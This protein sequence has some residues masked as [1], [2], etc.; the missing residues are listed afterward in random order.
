MKSALPILLFSLLLTPN[1][2]A[3]DDHDH[4]GHHHAEHAA[5]VHGEARLQLV[6]EADTLEME[7][8]APAQD[9]VGFEHAP[10][11]EQERQQVT[12]TITRLKDGKALF[13]FDGTDCVLQNA[14][15]ALHDS[16]GG[17]TE[18][19]SHYRFHCEQPDK[20]RHIEVQLASAFSRISQIHAEWILGSRQGARTLGKNNHRIE[21]K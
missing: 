5:H 16:K 9:V 12:D 7:L 11:N 2:A 3:A 21:V 20:L 10:E 4:P 18:F 17:H 6:M 8:Q 14:Q 1:P 19:H 15:A 13:R